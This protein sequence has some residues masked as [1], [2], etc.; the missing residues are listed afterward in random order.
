MN[1]I[2]LGNAVYHGEKSSK[3]LKDN[4]LNFIGEDIDNLLWFLNRAQ[5][6][7][8]QGRIE[9]QGIY[10][11]ATKYEKEIKELKALLNK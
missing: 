3:W 6:L 8:E 9:K 5:T 4:N 7:L 1:T 11:L 2:E 10:A